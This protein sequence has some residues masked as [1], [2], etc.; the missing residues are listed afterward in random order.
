MGLED[1]EYAT[2]SGTI[3]EIVNGLVL[4]QGDFLRLTSLQMRIKFLGAISPGEFDSVLEL[5]H[6]YG[7]TSYEEYLLP[8]E[9]DLGTL[10]ITGIEA[11]DR[12]VGKP[13]DD[14][15]PEILKFKYWVSPKIVNLY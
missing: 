6:S 5:T 3:Y 1:F 12:I 10:C 8:E 7:R 11:G 13:E 2:A 14:S 9:V 4:K 15:L